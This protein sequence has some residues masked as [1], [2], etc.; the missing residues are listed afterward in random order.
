MKNPKTSRKNSSPSQS[1]KRQ[2]EN[3]VVFRKAN[4]QIQKELDQLKELAKEDGAETLLPDENMELHFYCEC[5]DENCR[6]RIVMTL[7]KYKKLHQ[8]R[9]QFI[10][11]PDHEVISLEKVVVTNSKFSVVEK[12]FNPPEMAKSLSSTPINNV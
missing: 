7:S 12:F 11:C 1:Q 3:E 2:I 4:E 10:I 5:S 6:E 9:R 8:D